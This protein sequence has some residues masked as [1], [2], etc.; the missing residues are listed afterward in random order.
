V[1]KDRVT[2]GHAGDVVGHCARAA[3][4]TVLRL[5]P[6]RGIA[7]LRRHEVHVLEKRLEQLLQQ[8]PRLRRHAQHLVVPVDAFAE[9]LLELA[10]L[11]EHGL[12]EGDQRLRESPHFVDR[13]RPH[14]IE[15]RLGRAY[16]V[17][18]EEVDHAPDDLV[19][20][21]PLSDTRMLLAHDVVLA[22]EQPHVV[23]VA[24]LDETGAQ[25]VVDVVIVVRNLVGEVRELCFEPWLA[26]VDEALAQ[27][28][29]LAGV[30]Q[31]AVL[32]DALAALERQ[33]E[34]REV[35]V[36]LLEFVH[37]AQGLQVVLEPAV[38]AHALVERIL[39][40]VPERRVPEIVG[41]AD[42]LGE[43]FVQAQCA[44]DGA[45]DLCDFE[46][47]RDARAEEIAL[48]IDE[49]LRLVHEPAERI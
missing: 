39:P 34:S 46:R 15:I 23:Q 17:D 21:T 8:T 4:L 41:Q 20:E 7:M 32:E 12:A 14:L 48:V 10:M 30:L 49:D 24:D 36:A 44:G 13:R 16:Q 28:A 5:R 43:R 11:L 2:V 40:G 38:V 27:L 22:A 6:Q 1:L 37:D 45:C 42:G 47:V 18:D 35:G 33:V 26:P 3:L 31:R 9:E 29:E 25:P 19:H